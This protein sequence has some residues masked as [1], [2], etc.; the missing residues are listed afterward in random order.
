LHS[1][2]DRKQRSRAV[3][4]ACLHSEDWLQ[5]GPATIRISKACCC[6][7]AKLTASPAKHALRE[8]RKHPVPARPPSPARR[9]AAQI[10]CAIATAEPFSLAPSLRASDASR[11]WN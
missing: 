10:T 5:G 4:P 9:C 11:P 1:H 8:S 6:T 7:R 3:S 2:G